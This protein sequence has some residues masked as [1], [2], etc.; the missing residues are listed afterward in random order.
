VFF[1]RSQLQMSVRA[2]DAKP[3][4]K[5]LTEQ[6]LAS[7]ADQVGIQEMAP[8]DVSEGATGFQS[9]K[10]QH[11][12]RR[13]VVVNVRAS[14]AELITKASA[15]VWAPT[16]T[17][18]GSMFKQKKFTSL[19]GQTSMQ[20]DLRSVVLHKVSAEKVKS[21]FPIAVG[22]SITGVDD[23]YFSSTGKP[24]SMITH[25]HAQ[26]SNPFGLQ[27]DDVSVGTLLL[28][29]TPLFC[30]PTPPSTI[31]NNAPCCVSCAQT[32][33]QPTISVRMPQCSSK[34]RPQRPPFLADIASLSVCVRSSALP[35]LHGRQPRYVPP[36][37]FYS[38]YNRLSFLCLR[39]AYDTASFVC[40]SQ[41]RMA[42]TRFHSVASSLWRST[43]RWSLRKYCSARTRCCLRVLELRPLREFLVIRLHVG[44]TLLRIWVDIR[45]SILLAGFAF[46]SIL[47]D[48]FG[49]GRRSFHSILSMLACAIP[50]PCLL[51]CLYLPLALCAP[52]YTFRIQENQAKLQM[53][54][55]QQMPDQLLKVRRVLRFF[56]L[57]L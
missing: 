8:V 43:T 14:L 3:I 26:S 56:P 30:L 5:G 54:E 35:R 20:G 7:M 39:N 10:A 34:T 51:S 27:E 31:F 6:Q 21:T 22:A 17:Q 32:R 23:T 48:L 16:E 52:V 25:S 19:N 29:K 45:L 49:S 50:V 36:P 33:F 55:I 18:L 4:G 41:K 40:A 12:L 38:I 44:F 11:P 2:A 57:F 28:T 46:G 9:A 47:L 37:P 1:T 42:S 53:S 24:F 13:K 15:S